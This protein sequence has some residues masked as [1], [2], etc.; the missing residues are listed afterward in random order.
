VEQ[1]R[2]AALRGSP[3]RSARQQA[4]TFRL[5]E[6]SVCRI[7]HKDLHYR[8][9]KIQVAQELGEQDKVIGLQF[10][11]EFLDLVKNESNM[12]NTLLMSNDAHF[13]VSGH[14]K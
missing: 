7:L 3:R 6:C 14:V 12:V 4:L 5:N 11:N 8:S 13:R 10:W 9:Y 2:D 1:V